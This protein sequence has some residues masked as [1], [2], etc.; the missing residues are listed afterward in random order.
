M[1]LPD[2]L[3]ELYLTVG[4]SNAWVVSG[5]HTASGKPLLSNDPHLEV[6]IPSI[7]HLSHISY[8]DEKGNK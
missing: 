7:W 2:Y 6:R 5:K 1:K 8:Y 4:G 3:H